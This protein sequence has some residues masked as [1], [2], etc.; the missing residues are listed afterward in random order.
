MLREYFGLGLGALFLKE[1][2]FEKMRQDSGRVTKGLI[3]IL[4]VGVIVALVALI[5]N[6]LEWAITP[7]LSNLQNIV[8][9]ELKQMSWYRQNA[10]NPEFLRG[11]EQGYTQW[12]QFFGGTFKVDV[13][14]AVTNIIVNPLALALRWLLYGV[15]AYIIARMLGGKGT[16][17]QTLGCTALAVAPEILNVVTVVPFAQVGGVAIW[18]S[19]CAYLGIKV[20][21]ELSPWRAF[22]ATL[23]PAIAVVFVAIL[24]GCCVS[25]AIGAVLSGG[26]R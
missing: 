14:G 10:N 20:A 5:G 3:L 23:L 13:L 21:N 4:F 22:W 7:D 2:I 19:I 8:L 16:L 1:E 25:V 24:I 12:W 15:V 18:G 11:F 6:V 9:D 26:A 17:S